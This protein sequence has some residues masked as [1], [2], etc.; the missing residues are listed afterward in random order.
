MVLADI[1]ELGDSSLEELYQKAHCGSCCV[2]MLINVG[3][4]G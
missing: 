3:T 2:F 4:E 1:L